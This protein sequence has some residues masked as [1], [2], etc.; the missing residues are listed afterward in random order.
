VR[1]LPLP[2]VEKPDLIAATQRSRSI[3][4]FAYLATGDLDVGSI[5]ILRPALPVTLLGGHGGEMTTARAL[6]DSGADFTTFSHD[7]AELLGI[8]LHRDCEQIEVGVADG[9]S[10]VRYVF[11][12]GLQIEVV[13]E[14]ML[15]PVVMFCENLPIGL[16]GRRDFF[17]RYLV[18]FDHRNHD[19]FLERR[20]DPDEGDD[21]Y[22]MD[23]THRLADRR[24]A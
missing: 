20:V 14:K 4:K 19:F 23:A 15:L 6:I 17:E 16:L 22:V 10:S 8:D 21:D 5:A 11:T 7:W 12:K 18:L 3:G 2:A 9:K 1:T 24:V 13:G